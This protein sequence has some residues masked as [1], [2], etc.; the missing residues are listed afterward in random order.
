MK[1]LW[2]ALQL[3]SFYAKNKRTEEICEFSTWIRG[4]VPDRDYSGSPSSPAVTDNPR[5]SGDPALVDLSLTAGSH[6]GNTW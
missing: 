4:T 5:C 1:S 3:I 2:R 6:C